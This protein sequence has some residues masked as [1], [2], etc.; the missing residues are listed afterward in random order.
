MKRNISVKHLSQ[1]P[2]EKH[3]AELV[4]RKDIGHPD[5]LADG[6]AEAGFRALCKEYMAECYA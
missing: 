2:I 6:V 5:S 1:T 3:K 4:E